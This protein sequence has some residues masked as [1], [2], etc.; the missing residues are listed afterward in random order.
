MTY[1]IGLV[2]AILTATII[3]FVSGKL[4]VDLIGLLVLGSLGVTGLVSP[5]EALSGFSNPAVVT[6]WAM[7][8]ISAG[9]ANTGIAKFIGQQVLRL[10]G[11]G[12][13]RLIIVIMIT[14]GLLSGIM[15]NIG[16]AVLLLPVVMDVGRRTGHAPSRLLMPLAFGSL[17]GGLTTLIGTP[18]NLLVANALSGRGLA[19]FQLFDFTPTG[20]TILLGCILFMVL[21][22]RRLLPVR[23]PS[24]EF[25]DPK[26][27]DWGNIYDLG[28]RL[29]TVR[30]PDESFLAGK[31]LASSRLGATLGF[32]VIGILRNGRTILSPDPNAD[33]HPGDRLVVV[34]RPDRLDELSRFGELQVETALNESNGPSTAE[35]EMAKVGLSSSS[36]LIGQTL[37][38]SDFRRRFGVNVLA[39][40][41]K[42]SAIRKNLQ[43]IPLRP[44]D[45]LLV[46]G[47]THKIAALQE[48]DDFL[49]S[50]IESAEISRLHESLLAIRIPED[51]PLAGKT[52]AESHLGDAIGLT[53]ISIYRSGST[54]LA[55]PATE[56]LKVDDILLVEGDKEDLQAIGKLQ[57]LEIERKLTSDVQELE[58]EQIGLAEAVLSPHSSLFDQTLRQIGFREKYR[59][60]VV[61]IWRE[62][63]AYR[64]NL[65]N[66]PLRLG[67]GL[68]LYGH[69]DQM[70]RL[71]REPDFLVLYEEAQAVPNLEKAPLS[72]SILGLVLLPVL[73]GWLPISIMA[74]VGAGLM[75]LSRCLTMEEAY[76]AIDWRA[77]F[78]IAG[79]LPLGLALEQTGAARMI[80][81]QVVAFVGDY[82]AIGLLAGLFLITSIATQAM[83]SVATVVL[84]APIAVST[85]QD[86]GVSPYPFLMAVAVAASTGFHSPVSHPAN[87]LVLGPGG[88]RYSD[89]FKVG[90]PL[91][92]VVFVLVLLFVP[93]F[94][95]F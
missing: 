30:V 66:I 93:L 92:L 73:F 64:S 38:Q 58:T 71:A 46:Q 25:T 49:L 51:S 91:T 70:K 95:P 2:L 85:S 14:A 86:L 47:L 8:I 54:L 62:G 61:A 21:L 83:P 40:F 37:K 60:S 79:T 75:V 44:S 69:R 27:T 11:T 68:L 42:G 48:N 43:D 15:N 87:V 84:L 78:L 65:G 24:A 45:V 56:K 34:G 16:V 74:V 3:L 20:I 18:A 63:Q 53:V 22:G 55:P 33:L 7:F 13:A 26:K 39:I 1:G 82:G 5:S 52:L 31:T 9:L 28:E 57:K 4:R 35:I 23:D 90:I 32:N 10:G 29:F 36:P 19:S 81:D 67:D 59:L 41:R 89:F 80:A 88:Y 50:K 94:F 17:L 72:V 12:E 6:V 76:R 77:V